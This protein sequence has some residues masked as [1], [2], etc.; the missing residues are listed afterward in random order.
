MRIVV[1]GLIG[2]YSL[3]GVVW[4]YMQYLLG[5]RA[6]GHDVWYL[7]DTGMWPYHREREEICADCSTNVHHLREIMEAFD[8]GDRWIYRNE[9]DGT[10]HGVENNE[11]AERLLADCDVLINVSGACWLRDC[12]AHIPRKLFIDGDPMFTHIAMQTDASGERRARLR[13]HE[14]HFSFGLALGQPGCLVPI[15]E[16]HWQPTVQPVAIECWNNAP[17]AEEH[18]AAQSWTTVM[19]WVSYPPV[20]FEGKTYGQ[21]DLEFAR[22]FELPQRTKL[23]FLLAMGRGQGNQRPTEKLETAGWRIREPLD[24][25]PDHMAYRDFLAASRGEWSVAKHGYVAARTGWFSCR[26]ACYL[27]AGRPA[28]VQDTGWTDYLPAGAGVLAF[29]DLESAADALQRVEENY[30]AHCEAAREFARRHFAADR[31]CHDLLQNRP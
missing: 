23:P 8:L 27:A 5:C 30:A 15:G 18:P 29:S 20:E 6:L 7:E 1:S 4:D 28:V 11:T 3:G 25:I 17:A 24:L 22:F 14:A 31:V 16:F 10:Y 9:P 2:Q 21:K 19:N 13:A 26:T 12:T